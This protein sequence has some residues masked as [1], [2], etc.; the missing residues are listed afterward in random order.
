MEK[1]GVLSDE[2]RTEFQH[3]AAYL[4]D[5]REGVEYVQLGK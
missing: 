1:A 4:Y 2:I 5:K 3:D